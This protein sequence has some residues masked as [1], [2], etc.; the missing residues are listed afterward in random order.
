MARATVVHAL[1]SIVG[2]FFLR[3]FFLQVVDCQIIELAVPPYTRGW[4]LGSQAGADEFVPVR[5]LPSASSSP[6]SVRAGV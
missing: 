6:H 1:S 4:S 2:V 5:D 3:F